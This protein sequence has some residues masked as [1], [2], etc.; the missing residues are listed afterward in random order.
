MDDEVSV[1]VSLATPP[2][3]PTKSISTHGWTSPTTP[4]SPRKARSC[5][6]FSDLSR[7]YL[8]PTSLSSPIKSSFAVRLSTLQLP[9]LDTTHAACDSLPDV[10]GSPLKH[11]SKCQ[12]CL[13]IFPP[14]HVGR[15][16]NHSAPDR[17]ISDELKSEPLPDRLPAHN[18]AAV[19]PP[20][21]AKDSDCR[22]SSWIPQLGRH[23]FAPPPT[24]IHCDARNSNNE[25]FEPT[26][27]NT[28]NWEDTPAKLRPDPIRFSSSSLRPSQWVARGGL[29]S[30]SRALRRT[31]D[32]FI[33]SRRPHNVTRES[34]KL[35]RPASRLT[36]KER[37][38]FGGTNNG[39]PFDRRLQRSRRMNDELRSLRE[40]HS[41]ITVRTTLDRRNTSRISVRA[42]S[43]TS[44]V[45]QVSAGAVWNVGGT[46]A[47]NETVHGVSN[48]RGGM[49]G[50][51]TNAP[52]Y[53]SMFLS[54]SDPEAELETYERRL[55]LAFDVDQTERVLE[56]TTP[57]NSP[58]TTSGSTL[59]TIGS[60][61][62]H[63]WKDNAW[64]R[65][66]GST[67]LF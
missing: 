29:V 40:A 33:S 5:L 23:D 37:E 17:S 39:D 22:Y 49:L 21:Q 27:P 38:S 34:F 16:I 7:D 28:F 1:H 67:S 26:H 4:P 47:V 50:S 59:S 52:L 53:T 64:V 18:I 12:K 3:S 35:N 45:R 66:R 65:D 51:G 25:G 62:K 54:Q 8:S 31:P 55:A 41:V 43:F 30:A 57:P 6:F 11:S 42:G 13:S 24:P 15:S 58:A 48:G 46:S 63:V 2:L 56:H 61:I 20:T 10:L 9:K 60:P 14:K 19:I 32:R 44:G 36:G